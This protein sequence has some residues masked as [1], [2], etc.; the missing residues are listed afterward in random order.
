MS[1]PIKP[2]VITGQGAVCALGVGLEA[3]WSE[4]EQGHDGIR[5]IERFSTEGFNTHLAGMV[6][7]PGTLGAPPQ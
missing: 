5:V 6:P 2:V 3:I 4:L 1:E 7:L